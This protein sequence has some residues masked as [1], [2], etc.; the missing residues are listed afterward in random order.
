MNRFSA[1]APRPALC[2]AISH[3]VY[4]LLY[5]P[6]LLFLSQAITLQSFGDAWL[7]M[8][9]HVPAAALNCLLLLCVQLFL[10]AL[11][12]GYC[13]STF[14]TGALVL[15]PTLVSYYKTAINGFPLI[16][17]D[18]SLLTSAGDILEYAMP[19][20]QFSAVTLQSL[21]ICLLL[22]L[23]AATLL[24]SRAPKSGS[25]AA[26]LLFALAF[27]TLLSGFGPGVLRD[28]AVSLTQDC[29]SQEERLER[30]G[31]LYGLYAAY[32]AD[33]SV[34]YSSYSPETVAELK[35]LLYRVQQETAAESVET[36][37]PH[38]LMI[39]SE[40]FFDVTKLEQIDFE[41]DPIPN[42]HCLSETYTNGP[43][44]S[45]TY[46][47]GTGNVELE[48]L[49]GF[50]SG[51][52]KEADALTALNRKDG[53][54]YE[55]LPSI[56]R[57]ARADGYDTFYIHSHNSALYRRT[58]SMP[59]LG[60]DH[61]IFSDDFDVPISFNG[62]YVSDDTLVN[63]IIHRFEDR[64]SD[65]PVF[66]QI[67]T[68]ENHQPYTS[69][70]YRH[71]SGIR[72][73]CDGLTQD[74]RDVLD[75]YI[76]GLT[77]VDAALGRLVDYFEACGEPVMI[78]FYGDHKPSLVVSDE[79]TVY[80]ALGYVPSA[81]SSQWASENL[82]DM[83]LTDYL[84]WTNYEAEPAADRTETS[85]LIGANV[86]KRAGLA[87]SVYFRYLS[88]YVDGSYLLTRQNLFVEADGT[89]SSQTPPEYAQMVDERRMMQ[90][91]AAYGEQSLLRY[92]QPEDQ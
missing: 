40:S 49:T 52:I 30:C 26:F 86:L 16:L 57:D 35:N 23:F 25:R 7:W 36:V 79:E 3:I 6:V 15:L 62:W 84:V 38:I 17:S 50:S 89:I 74:V 69:E 13:F 28:A 90:Y 76:T 39:L 63:E 5:P 71:D 10:R 56:A 37:R 21:G 60:F 59:A 70:K 83:L 19:E 1:R 55:S 33:A 31:V 82:R 47:G 67:A 4:L 20:V 77:H 65:A 72:Y 46:A 54:V 14:L 32:A 53:N 80:S 24:R 27:P 58:E 68:M 91:D 51:L 87:R 18:F 42:F 48:V 11:F 41:D 12:G 9:G 85:S 73:R 45:S 29:S 8:G 92:F 66:M 2:E 43:F 44:F 78:V 88:D 75:S 81:D 22:C 64:T 61:V 34:D